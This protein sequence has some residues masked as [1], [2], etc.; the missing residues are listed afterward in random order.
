MDT[1]ERRARK[2]RLLRGLRPRELAVDQLADDEGRIDTGPIDS[3]TMLEIMA[4][5]EAEFGLDL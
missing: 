4:F 3:L 5:L 1:Q 2:L